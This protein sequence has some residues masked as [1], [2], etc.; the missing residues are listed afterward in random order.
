[1]TYDLDGYI[2]QIQKASKGFRKFIIGIASEI[3]QNDMASLIADR[4]INRG[5]HADGGKDFYSTKPILIG[6]SSFT[7]KTAANKVLGSKR[8]RKKLKWVSYNGN[9]LA[10][11]EGG[12]KKIR[13][14]E[15]RTIN[16][17]NYERTGR[18]WKGFGVIG[19]KKEKD[20]ITILLGGKNKDSQEKINMNSSRYGGSIIGANEKEEKLINNLLNERVNEYLSKML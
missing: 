11:L 12:Y 14:I 13:E 3:A 5:Q 10:V 9:N 6:Q 19:K 1:M 4:M 8:K 16:F 7:S 18:M 17:M 15:G 20:Y 2:K